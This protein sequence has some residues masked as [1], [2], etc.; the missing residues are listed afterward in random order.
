MTNSFTILGSSSGIP[1][2]DRACSGYLL[3]TGE[4]LSLIDCGGGVASSFL[5]CGFDPMKLDRIFI[6][7]SHS[8][9]VAELTLFVQMLHGRSHGGRVRIYLPD[10]FVEPF[11]A[12]LPAVYL[13]PE[14]LRLDLEIKGYHEGPVYSG[15]FLVTAIG[16]SH[17]AKLKVEMNQLGYPNRGECFSLKIDVGERCILYSADVGSF[18]DIR[19]HLEKVDYAIV[20]TSHID[21]EAV[22]E[23]ARAKSTVGTYILTHLGNSEEVARLKKRIEESGLKNVIVA[24]DGLRLEF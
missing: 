16:N 13:P 7:H 9:H 6:S 4:S 19:D 22:F 2:P 10:E 12:Y 24:E 14:R 18:E 15:E 3:Q 20:E 11:K 1:S 8:D 21:I 23:H 5:R 17:Q